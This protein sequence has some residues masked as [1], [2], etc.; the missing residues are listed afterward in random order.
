MP[1]DA[2]AQGDVRR[3]VGDGKRLDDE[4]AERHRASRRVRLH[5]EPRARARRSEALVSEERSPQRAGQRQG[6]RGVI[7]VVVRDE[8]PER[9][10]RSDE[11]RPER[12]HALD[13]ARRPDAGVDQ[14]ALALGL[15]DEAV[16]AGAAAE[17]EDAQGTTW[18]G[19]PATGTWRRRPRTIARCRR[20]RTHRP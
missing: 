10:A 7:A 12:P 3:V 8:E 14:Q 16:A 4:G 19:S 15:D 5:V 18:T 20:W 1:P 6:V 13:G 9:R 11:L 2:D 17:D